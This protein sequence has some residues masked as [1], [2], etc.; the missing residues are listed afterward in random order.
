MATV[1]N[2]YAKT[3]QDYLEQ[4]GKLDLQ[5]RGPKLG[6]TVD[7]DEVTITMF[8]RPYQV[9][10]R[11]ITDWS[12]RQPTLDLCVIL[13]RYL[14][15]CP[16]VQPMAKDWATFRGLRDTGPLTV[17]FSSDVER[18][19]AQLFTGDLAR[20]GEAGRLLEGALRIWRPTTTC[21]WSSRPCPGCRFFCCSMPKMK[22]FRPNV[23][24]FLNAGPKPIWMP[25]VWPCWAGTCIRLSRGLQA[26]WPGIESNEAGPSPNG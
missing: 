21:P 13:A 18:A 20:L 12:G 3:Y 22:S 4:L 17:Y 15:L 1:S 11:G 14:I 6:V 25:N 2:V 19:I 26:P 24:C 9:S 7:W 8:G 16:E 10:P 23:Q 5:S